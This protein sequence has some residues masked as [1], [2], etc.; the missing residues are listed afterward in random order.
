M[1]KVFEAFKDDNFCKC[2]LE[3]DIQLS[4]YQYHPK[5]SATLSN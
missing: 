3:E 5:I 2:L 4:D 1:V